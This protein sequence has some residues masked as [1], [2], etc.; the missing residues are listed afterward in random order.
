MRRNKLHD[1]KFFNTNLKIFSC[2]LLS[3]SSSNIQHPFKILL[4]YWNFP[5]LFFEILFGKLNANYN[6]FLLPLHYRYTAIQLTFFVRCVENKN[7]F[8]WFMTINWENIFHYWV[9]LKFCFFKR[10]DFILLAGSVMMLDI[11]FV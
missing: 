4:L 7:W 9:E 2:C 3:S 11:V 5:L 6:E 1:L 8:T 10:L